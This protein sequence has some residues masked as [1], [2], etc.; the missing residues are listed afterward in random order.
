MLMAVMLLA[1]AGASGDWV[2]IALLG[3][4]SLAIIVAGFGPVTDGILDQW[5][6]RYDVAIDGGSRDWVRARLRRSRSMRWTSFGLGSVI[7]GLPMYMNVIDPS[8]SGDT[9]RVVGDLNAPWIA[10][11]LGSLVAELTVVQRPRGPRVAE[12]QRR[13]WSD[14][15]SDRWLVVLVVA[16]T[17]GVVGA[18]DAMADRSFGR[19]SAVVGAVSAVFGLFAAVFGMRSIVD[20]PLVAVEGYDR[21]LDEALR[22]DGAHHLVGAAVALSVL[23]AS[24]SLAA[25][26]QTGPLGLIV[27]LGSWIGVACWW[28]LARQETWNVARV[29][30]SRS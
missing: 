14:Y 22:A 18:I 27:T 16:A 7:A 15:V 28:F 30:W 11:A 24:A 2:M 3:G 19:S 17:L 1:G 4:L 21:L 6:L 25:A 13:R 26:V 5:C 12:V 20:R 29:R 8:L 9:A 23:G 10:A